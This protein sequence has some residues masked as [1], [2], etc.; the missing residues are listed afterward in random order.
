MRELESE[1]ATRDSEQVPNADLVI[2]NGTIVGEGGVFQADLI[3][4]DGRISVI[5]A[6]S[7]GWESRVRIDARGLLVLPGGIDSHTHFEE[8]DP[9]LLEGFATGGEAAAA[10]GLTTV[11]E[12]PQAHPTTTTAE[13]L[14]EKQ[15]IV[16]QNAVVDMALWGGVIGP[17]AQS[18]KDLAGMVAGGAAAFKSFMASSSPFFPAVDNAQLLWAMEEASRLGVPYGLHAEDQALLADGL[19]RMQES[20]RNDPMA[21]AESRPPLVETVAVNTALLLAA[22][23]GCHVHICHAASAAALGL[24]R[25]AKARGVRVTAETC[26]QYLMLNTEDLR[27]RRVRRCAPALRDQTEVDAIWE[28]VLGGTIDLIC[29]DHVG[30]TIESK[31]AGSDDI[32]QAP[33]GLS[34]V[35]TLLPAFYLRSSGQKRSP[36]AAIRR[37]ARVEPGPAFRSL[38]PQREPG[39]WRRRRHHLA[40]SGSDLDRLE[41][42]CAAPP[43]VDPV[44]RKSYQ[45]PRRTHDPARGNDLRRRASCRRSHPGETWYRKVLTTRLWGERMKVPSVERW[46]DAA[47]IDSHLQALA[48]HGARGETGVARLVYSPEWSAAQDQVATWMG[49]AGLR[50]ERDAVGNVWGYLDGRQ[51]GDSLIATGSHIDSQNPGGRYDGALGVVAAIAALASLRQRFGVPERTLAAVSLVEEESSRFPTANIWGSRA[52][53]GRVGADEP[54]RLRGYDGVTMAEAMRDAGFDPGRVGEA[55]RTDV[56]TFIELHIEQG[57]YL[58]QAGLP[59]GIVN[60]ITGY[61]Q[62]LVTLEGAAN[63]A[64]TTPMDTRRDPMAGAVEVISGVINTAHRMGRPAVT[65]VGRMTVTPNER[66]VI[67]RQVAF[68]LDTRSPDPSQLTTLI[69]RHEALIHEVVQR[70]DLHVR[71]ASTAIDNPS[72]PISRW[73]ARWKQPPLRPGFPP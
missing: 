73:L 45:R 66:A 56:D 47:Q 1:G 8:P 59:V 31:Q 2:A 67:P 39:H 20:G 17:P 51:A 43:E 16:A 50:V 19:Q 48:E 21:H 61:R 44:R 62:Y 11:V 68:T 72:C 64:G 33:L 42:R 15:A 41:R 9:R 53:I 57:P 35:Q 63:H 10:G 37:L 36:A 4:N 32:F 29:S 52:I 54:A 58:E 60:R 24:I 13:H 22:Q 14:R 70:R 55:R 7:S 5:T 71:F 6:D 23:T 26:P 30:Y 46:I 69:A 34:G 3:V 28:F 12:M 49:E 25:E 65:T 18:D 40:R 27:R 38:S